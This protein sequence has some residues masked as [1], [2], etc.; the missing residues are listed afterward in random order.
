MPSGETECAT[1]WLS[2]SPEK[3]ISGV[4]RIARA[5]RAAIEVAG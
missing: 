5:A 2:L 3:K 4:H 1:A